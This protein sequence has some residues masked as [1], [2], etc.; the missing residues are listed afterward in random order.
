MISC[1]AD[2]G[3]QDFLRSDLLQSLAVDRQG[4]EPTSR[5]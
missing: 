5:Y 4:G 2:I 3:M 1:G